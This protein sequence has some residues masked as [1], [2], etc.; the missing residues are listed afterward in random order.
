MAKSAPKRG[1]ERADFCGG[2]LGHFKGIHY[3]VA[4]VR[5]NRILIIVV[6]IVVMAAAAASK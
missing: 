3:K 1:Q 2:S 6:I 4:P 5:T